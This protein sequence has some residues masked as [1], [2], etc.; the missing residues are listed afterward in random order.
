MARQGKDTV[1]LVREK[2][3]IQISR[4]CGVIIKDVKQNICPREALLVETYKEHDIKGAV[5]SLVNCRSY[6]SS[7]PFLLESQA[8]AVGQLAQKGQRPAK[9]LSIPYSN[10]TPTSCPNIYPHP[11]SPPAPLHHTYVGESTRLKKPFQLQHFVPFQL[12]GTLNSTLG[13]SPTNTPFFCPFFTYK[14]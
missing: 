11:L 6:F 9:A 1:Y 5:V 14:T 13:L 8:E 2:H 4:I 10:G 12:S 3:V 7:F